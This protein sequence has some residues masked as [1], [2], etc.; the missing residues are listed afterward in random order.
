ML[1]LHAIARCYCRASLHYIDEAHTDPADWPAPLHRKAT[2]QLINPPQ[3][4]PT[5]RCL[6]YWLLDSANP[7]PT[8][9]STGGKH[10]ESIVRLLIHHSTAN[11]YVLPA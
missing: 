8:P 11:S 9:A 2:R 6:L 10:Y 7:S 3:P 5:H 1:R 4:V